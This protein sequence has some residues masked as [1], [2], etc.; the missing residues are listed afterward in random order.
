MA[1]SEVSIQRLA[2]CDYRLVAVMKEVVKHFPCQII[3]GERT[4][5]EQNEAVK[6]GN[7]KTP[8]PTSKHNV[9]PSKAVDVFPEPLDWNDKSKFIWFAGFVLGVAASKG[10]KLRW[11]GNWDRDF[12][13]LEKGENDL[14]HF[15]VDDA[16]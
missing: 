7:S 13:P 9:H 5:A 1:F 3:C 16:E 11:G 14:V 15:E 4:E 2:T 12:T 10:F 6:A 8:W